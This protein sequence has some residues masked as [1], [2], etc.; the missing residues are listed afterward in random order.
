MQNL[1]ASTISF[2]QEHEKYSTIKWISENPLAFDALLLSFLIIIVLFI[3]LTRLNKKLKN[4]LDELKEQKFALDEHAILSI[5]NVKGDITYVNDKF[6]QV[7]GYSREELL[8]K[9]HRILNSGQFDSNFWKSM[10]QTVSNGEIWKNSNICNIKKDGSYYWVDTL[11]I[12]FMKNGKPDHYVAIR[13]DI[14]ENKEIEIELEKLYNES[15]DIMHEKENMLKKIKKLAYNDA[16]TNIPNRL[17]FMYSFDRVLATAQ[18]SEISISLMFIDL[19]GFKLINDTLDHDT[20]DRVLKEVAKIL[21]TTLRKDDLYG[22][23]GGDEFVVI[24]L[25]TK[26]EKDLENLCKKLLE[27]INKIELPAIVKETFG[28]SIGVINGVPSQKTTT[29][30]LLKDADFLM[31]EVKKKDKNNFLIK[32]Y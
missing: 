6:L 17:S 8:G 27:N 29:E 19:D 2:G 30:T 24:T 20:G 13:T 18:R 11:I 9:N 26:N 7:S 32:Q 16:L 14:T 31:Y 15:E 1:Y 12:P 23:L 28:A 25:D 22:R 5:T 3:Y 4:T 10:Y 21:K